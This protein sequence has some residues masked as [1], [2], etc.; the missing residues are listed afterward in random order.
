MRAGP[1][2]DREPSSL[3]W[4]IMGGLGAG[5]SPYCGDAAAGRL[6]GVG[7]MDR[8]PVVYVRGYAGATTGIDTAVDRT[9]A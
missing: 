1:V 8:L 7:L 2:G 3:D 5:V 4:A 9:G 6:M